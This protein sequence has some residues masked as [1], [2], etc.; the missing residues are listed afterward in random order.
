MLA[1]KQFSYLGNVIYI[2]E[3]SFVLQELIYQ[4]G[5]K[6]NELCSKEIQGCFSSIM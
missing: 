2:K 5:K 4:C 3:K 1:F 6:L